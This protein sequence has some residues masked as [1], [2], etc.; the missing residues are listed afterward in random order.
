MGR[1]I[2]SAKW[3]CAGRGWRRAT[4]TC[5][6]LKDRWT[7]D[8]WF[9]TGD[10]A[11]IDAEGY[12]RIV[13]RTKDLIKSAANGSARWT[14]K[15][16][17]MGYPGVSEAAVIGVPHPKWEERPLAV[18]VV[19]EA[20]ATPEELREFLAKICEVAASR[21]LHLRRRASAHVN[22]Q[23]AEAEAARDVCGLELGRL[24]W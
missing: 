12:V 17:L 6:G 19:K 23:A 13:D 7:E 5:R 14:W 20:Q 10:V 15:T 11:S 21:R 2:Q 18:V 9:R 4:S 22:R 16:R 24:V 3:K 8:G 1:R